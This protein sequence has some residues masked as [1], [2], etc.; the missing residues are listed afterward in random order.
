MPLDHARRLL[1]RFDLLRSPCDL[2]L[3]VFFARHPL[4]LLAREQLVLLLG[5][6]PTEITTSLGLLQRAGLLIASE[7]PTY[8]AQKYVFAAQN[9]E[10]LP[11]LLQL[12]STRQGRLVLM[13]ALRQRS[14][15]ETG[16][17]ATR[18]KGDAAPR[19]AS[20]RRRKGK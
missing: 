6:E 16:G 20:N 13:R 9:A 4:T 2:D 5:Y 19:P 1:E 14:A 12:A 7:D 15:G 10:W 8:V 18:A 11:D 17:P 3:L